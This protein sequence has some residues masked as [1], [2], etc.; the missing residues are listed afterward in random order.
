M[1]TPTNA[2]GPSTRVARNRWRRGYLFRQRKGLA[3]S[4][5]DVD[6]EESKRST[7]EVSSFWMDTIFVALGVIALFASVALGLAILMAE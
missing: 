5:L 4:F 3:A 7:D 2:I 6:M 1:T